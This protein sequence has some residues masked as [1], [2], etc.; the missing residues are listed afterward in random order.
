MNISGLLVQIYK[1]VC[2]MGQEENVGS[3]NSYG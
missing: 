3:V 1:S 2:M